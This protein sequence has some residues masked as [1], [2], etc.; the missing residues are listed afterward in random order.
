MRYEIAERVIKMK[1]KSRGFTLTEIMIVTV[2]IGLTT[3]IA[4]P[5]F[6]NAKKTSETAVCY[7]NAKQLQSALYLAAN[8]TYAAPPINDLSEDQIKA[9]VCPDYIKIMPICKSGQYYTDPNGNIMCQYHLYPGSSV[10]AGVAGGPP[11][12]PPSP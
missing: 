8:T 10:A 9:I 11:I 7:A 1:L 3:A 2:I 12:V 4:I 5:N 6:A